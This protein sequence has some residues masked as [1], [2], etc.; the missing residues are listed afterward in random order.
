LDVRHFVETRP[1]LYHFT[2][3]ANLPSI[4]GTRILYSAALI[5]P[6]HVTRRTEKAIVDFRGQRIVIRDQ[7][8]LYQRHIEFEGGW[9][10][11]RYLREI[12]R[13]IFFWPGNERGPIS[14]GV[15]LGSRYTDGD[16]VLIRCSLVD[17]VAKNPT[18]I[19][20]FCRFNSGAPRTYLGRKS[21]RGPDTFVSI[22]GWKWTRS[23]VVEITCTDHVNL[24]AATEIKEVG[25]WVGLFKAR[26]V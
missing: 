4:R 26:D 8:P 3:A 24:P 1:M 10:F 21:P 11:D 13:R 2:S 20:C 16:E 12:N 23:D 15:R 5:E 17:F 7:R 19:P 18:N 22:A 14:S 25:H 9:D 6:G